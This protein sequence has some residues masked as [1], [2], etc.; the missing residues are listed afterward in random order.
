MR[1]IVIAKMLVLTLWGLYLA[2]GLTRGAGTDEG[3]ASSSALSSQRS[4]V[5]GKG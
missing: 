3:Q 1:G 2:I 5:R 4:P